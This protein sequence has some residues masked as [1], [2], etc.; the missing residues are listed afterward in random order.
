MPEVDGGEVHALL[1]ADS[2]LKDIPIIFL[3]SMV[4]QSEVDEHKGV[5]GGSF[6]VAKSAGTSRLISAIAE[7]LRP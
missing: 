5:I 6:Y 7:H 2:A 4:L 1:K 3:T